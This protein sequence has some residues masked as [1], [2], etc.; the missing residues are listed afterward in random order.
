MFV[1]RG[2]RY[3]KRIGG[4]NWSYILWQVLKLVARRLLQPIATNTVK[5]FTPRSVVR[6]AVLASAV[7]PKKKLNNARKNTISIEVVFFIGRDIWASRICD[8]KDNGRC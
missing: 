1:G 3:I 8:I 4:Q 7:K 6:V 5:I 2:G